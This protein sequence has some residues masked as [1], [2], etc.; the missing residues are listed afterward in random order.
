MNP[1]QDYRQR[2]A[3]VG[4]NDSQRFDTADFKEMLGNALQLPPTEAEA[5]VQEGANQGCWI[6]TDAGIQLA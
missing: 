2:L 3:A 1:A 5:V 6:V 4:M